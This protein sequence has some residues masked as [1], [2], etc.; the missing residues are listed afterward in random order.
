MAPTASHVLRTAHNAQ[1]RLTAMYASL[2]GRKKME[3][4][5][6]ADLE[7]FYP[8]KIASLAWSIAKSVK[9]KL[10]ALSVTRRSQT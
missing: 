1:I 8:M 10:A 6:G 5:Y 9:I 7:R 4:A 2:G 3:S